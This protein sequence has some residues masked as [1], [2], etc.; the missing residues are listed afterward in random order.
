MTLGLLL[1]CSNTPAAAGP[2]R[3]IKDINQTPSWEM[4]SFPGAFHHLGDVTLFRAGT[5]ETGAEL[6]RTD[7]TEAETLRGE[8]AR[9]DE[10]ARDQPAGA[11]RRGQKGLFGQ[12]GPNGAGK[13]TLMRTLATLQEPDSGRILLDGQDLSHG[14]ET[15]IAMDEMLDIA[16]F[17]GP[18]DASGGNAPILYSGRHRVTAST[19]LSLVVDGRPEY[20]GVDPYLLRIDRNRADNSKRIEEPH[21][22]EGSRYSARRAVIGSTRVARRAGTNVAAI[23]TTATIATTAA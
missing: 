12:L 17:S 10:R 20:V 8:G 22:D 6:W 15:A 2:A 4:G 23:E 5:P 18:P 14:A 11:A 19:Q 7:G 9:V 3:L 1:V 16:V 13:S 21:P